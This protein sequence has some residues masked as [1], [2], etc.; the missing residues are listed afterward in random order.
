MAR[1]LWILHNFA[2]ENLL[3]Q[4]VGSSIINYLQES[5]EVAHRGIP[6]SRPQPATNN[7]VRDVR[8]TWLVAPP[9][10]MGSTLLAPRA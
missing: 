4:N 9:T 6:S 5:T 1:K 8:S 10:L 2:V 7:G 3:P